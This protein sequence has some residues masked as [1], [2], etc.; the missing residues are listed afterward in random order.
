MTKIKYDKIV[1]LFLSIV[2]MFII[3]NNVKNPVNSVIWMS[4]ILFVLWIYGIISKSRQ[5][6]H[7]NIIIRKNNK[8]N[9]K[10]TFVRT[11]KKNTVVLQLQIGH[12]NE[13]YLSSYTHYKPTD[14]E[15]SRYQKGKSIEVFV[16]PQ[17]KA[18]ILIPETAKVKTNNSGAKWGFLVWFAIISTSFGIPLITH[19]LDH[20]NRKFEDAICIEGNEKQQR[21]WELRFEPQNKILIN[22][23]DP[24]K[25]KKIKTIKD[26]RETDLD[27]N[28]RFTICRQNQNIVVIGFGNTPVY[29]VYDTAT[30]QKISGLKEFE[31]SNI[32]MKKG[33]VS[34]EKKYINSYYTMDRIIEIITGDGKKCFYNISKDEFYLSEKKLQS[35]I[36][37]NDLGVMDSSL[38]SFAFSPVTG[39]GY[40]KFLYSIKSKSIKDKAELLKNSGSV[41]F[42]N[43]DFNRRKKYKCKKCYSELLSKVPFLESSFLYI[44]TSFAVILSKQS[45]GNDAAEQITIIDISGK[46][47]ITIQ[48]KDF[49]NLKLIQKEKYH[50]Q[51]NSDLKCEHFK[52]KMIIYFG[53]YGAICLELN[54]GKTLRKYEP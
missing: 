25:N 50:P 8:T 46:N 16:N 3:Y 19:L 22:I 20:S 26:K 41:N 29:D 52:N 12:A 37:K 7:K 54:M 14:Y 30:Y 43:E 38:V 15:R 44:D 2:A 27:Y 33:I 28:L 53:E 10:I 47:V 11:Y 42:N 31:K 17:N 32:T 5:R 49:P 21:I 51:K 36:E 35:F 18:E 34:I 6:R 4:G 1:L 39:N 40:Q 48:K 24:V 9:A 45:V 23:L 13:T